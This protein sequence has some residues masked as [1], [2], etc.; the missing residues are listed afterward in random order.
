VEVEEVALDDIVK[1]SA[2]TPVKSPNPLLF[3]VGS[4]PDVAV[5]ISL[6]MPVKLDV[7]L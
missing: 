3:A 5:T 6:A 4:F 1:S 2:E 7:V